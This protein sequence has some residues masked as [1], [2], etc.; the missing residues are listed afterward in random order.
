[1]SSAESCGIILD[2]KYK[3]ECLGVNISFLLFAELSS[4]APY[5]WRDSVLARVGSLQSEIVDFSRRLLEIKAKAV[6]D[7]DPAT[8][9]Q[10]HTLLQY[11]S[12]AMEKSIGSKF[13]ALYDA[14][15]IDVSSIVNSICAEHVSKLL[16]KSLGLRGVKQYHKVIFL[17]SHYLE[18]FCIIY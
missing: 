17:F 14:M 3:G 13:V 8:R 11:C 6:V 5:F 4:W 7:S 15:K 18:M 12:S 1:M 2:P 9:M 10:Q 16:A